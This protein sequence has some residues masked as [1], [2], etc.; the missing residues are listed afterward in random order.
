MKKLQMFLALLLA[1]VMIIS[2]CGAKEEV[3][4][5]DANKESATTESE[6]TED[7]K[8][9]ADTEEAETLEHVELSWY[10]IGS[11]Q[12]D[13][14]AVYEKANEIIKEKINA[15]VNFQ[16]I[17]WG[18]YDDKMNLMIN[19]GEEFDICFTANWSNNYLQNVQKEAFMPLDDLLDTYAPTLK[20]IVPEK[21]WNATKVNGNI[22]GLIN[23]QISTMTNSFAVNKELADKYGFDTST[24]KNYE[25]LEPLLAAIKEGESDVTPLGNYAAAGSIWGMHLAANGFDEIGGRNIPGVIKVTD[26]DLTVINQFESPEFLAYATTNRDF[27]EKRLY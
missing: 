17:D 26:D 7:T 9:S 19:A 20:T 4:G 24:I 10:Y 16:V 27:Y 25:D 23:Y 1:M 15:T 14:N 21:F 13:Q 2:G 5:T 8:E 6:K 22:Y 18:S 12:T 3:K 11:P